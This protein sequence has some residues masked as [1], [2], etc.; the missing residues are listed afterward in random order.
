MREIWKDITGFEGIYQVSNKGRIK[1][2]VSGGLI[3]KT[4]IL[5]TNYEAIKFT[6]NGERTSH[7]VHRLVA[8]EF[9]EGYREHLD[10]NHIDADR[11][12]NNSWNLE[13]VTRKENIHDSI[14]RGSF[15]IESAHKKA[16]E[17]VKKP[18]IQKT[19][20]GEVIKE[21]ESIRTAGKEMG[22]HENSIGKACRGVVK[23][24]KG[25]VWEFKNR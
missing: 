22:V 14:R 5:N 9:C 19:L 13:W 17:R 3:M 11:L 10:V 20:D 24:S 21:Y 25:F 16:R 4:Y 12:N 8:R 1:S 6:V 2:I 23:T 18:V 7:L 15:N